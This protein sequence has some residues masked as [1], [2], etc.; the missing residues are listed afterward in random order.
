MRFAI[1]LPNFGPYGDP[2]VLADLAREAE[3]AGWDGFFIW[4]HVQFFVPGQRVPVVD[5][6]VALAAV[7]CATSR[8]RF[9][10][11]VTP[12]ARRR[13]WKLARE[14]V[15][16]DHLSGGRLILGV[17][18][19]DPAPTEFG[20]LGEPTD[21]VLRAGLLDEGLEVLT[22]LW[23]GE[24]FTFEGRHF[25]I[26]DALFLPTPL[27]APRIPIWVAGWWPN[28]RPMR[29]AAR[30]DGAFPGKLDAKG[31]SW[32]TPDDVRDV[33]AYVK[34]HREGDAPFDVVAGGITPD[35]PARAAEV[36]APFA[37]AGVT[38]WNVGVPDLLSPLET[39]R[40]RIRSGPPRP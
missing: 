29:R 33:V 39:M 11:M 30:W 37:E 26:R 40:A 27:Q 13:P 28:K 3:D 35:E 22:G 36:V 14:S 31:Y 5:P 2:R 21:A 18:L 1:N 16:L 6:W 8:I 23:S 15:T 25:Q 20:A 17:G 24:P 19:G 38:W 32:L 12:I 34:A 7:A 9:G 4:D 10:P